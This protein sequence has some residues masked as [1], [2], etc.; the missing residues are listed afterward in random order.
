[1][2]T[3]TTFETTFIRRWK[4]P[5][6]R[7]VLIVAGTMLGLFVAVGLPRMVLPKFSDKPTG[8]N[9]QV[10][11]IEDQGIPIPNA[12]V[13]V[14]AG[15]GQTDHDGQCSVPQEYLAK[16]VKGLSGTC[17]LEGEMRVEAAGFISWRKSLADV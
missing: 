1:M 7:A 13:N 14:G 9:F 17:R 8:L 15:A 3:E 2:S 5:S 16:G 4:R 6:R 11:V 12:N 10:Q